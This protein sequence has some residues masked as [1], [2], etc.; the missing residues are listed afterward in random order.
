MTA[1]SEE[2]VGATYKYLNCEETQKNTIGFSFETKNE[3]TK[4]NVF[5]VILSVPYDHNFPSL[6]IIKDRKQIFTIC[7]D[8]SCFYSYKEKE[9][10]EDKF[11]G[12]FK[13]YFLQFAEYTLSNYSIQP[14]LIDRVKMPH[15]LRFELSKE[16]ETGIDKHVFSI[17]PSFNPC[18]WC[19]AEKKIYVRYNLAGYIINDFLFK[20]DYERTTPITGRETFTKK[21]KINNKKRIVNIGDGWCKVIK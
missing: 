7:I 5:S 8:R 15:C 10:E 20:S 9:I 19:I 21:K 2:F 4:N 16:T 14:I 18:S 13:E 12:V 1:K 17:V 11:A 3:T 6:E